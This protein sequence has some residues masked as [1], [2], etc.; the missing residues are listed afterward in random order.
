MVVRAALYTSVAIEHFRGIE[1]LELRDLSQLNLLV[2]RNN[3]GK[4]TVL[5]AL[6][7]LTGPSNPELPLRINVQRGL[8]QIN[9]HIWRVFFTDLDTSRPVRLRGKF[10]S[11]YQERELTVQPR[12]RSRASVT[13]PSAAALQSLDEA[14]GSSSRSPASIS[15][16]TLRYSLR[17]APGKRPED[18]TTTV[19]LA[20]AGVLQTQGDAAHH[21]VLR[22]VLLSARVHPNESVV[23]FNNIQITK[24]VERVVSVLQRIEPR[25]RDLAVTSEGIIYADFGLPN[26]IPVTAAGDG[27]NRLLSLMLTM[28]DTEDGI[29]LVDEIDTGFHYSSL[30]VLWRAVA[31]AAIDFNVQVIATTHSLECVQAY[32][33]IFLESKAGLAKLIR[34]ERADEIVHA[35]LYDMP[36]LQASL[37]SGWEMR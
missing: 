3:C 27:L 8:P 23:R 26:L 7:L 2:G 10:S 17:T 14:S 22:S 1:Q 34:L 18:I 33:A 31:A 16:L 9:E 19:E 4:S 13:V 6:F 12:T 15:G 37:E 29:V 32:N 20:D 28:L 11:P 21:E 5:E 35:V 30:D 25:L 24:R 36:V